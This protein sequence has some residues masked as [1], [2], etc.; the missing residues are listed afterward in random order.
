M[1]AIHE[2]TCMHGL[3]T[4][5][6]PNGHQSHRWE[7]RGSPSAALDLYRWAVV[8]HIWLFYL[9]VIKIFMH[10]WLFVLCRW[11]CSDVRHI[12]SSACG[13]QWRLFGA[14]VW[15]DIIPCEV[16]QAGVLSKRSHD[17]KETGP[18]S[19]SFCWC[20]DIHANHIWPHSARLPGPTWSSNTTGNTMPH[21][22]ATI[23]SRSAEKYHQGDI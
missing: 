9:L 17:P 7:A 1:G 5:R 21:T 11:K 6:T 18:I 8:K 14:S 15:N 20:L 4:S 12:S 19:K 13:Q 10:T 22:G 2:E 3:H 23:W 16:K